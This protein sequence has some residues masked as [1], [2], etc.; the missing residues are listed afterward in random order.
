MGVCKEKQIDIHVG[1]WIVLRGGKGQLHITS[2]YVWH[3]S[4]E[5]E[6][7]WLAGCVQVEKT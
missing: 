1:G 5:Y 2:L 4:I 7:K 6:G 3:V